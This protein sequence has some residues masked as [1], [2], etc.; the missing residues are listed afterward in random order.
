MYM[1]VCT[2]IIN[3]YYRLDVCPSLP[4]PMTPPRL[5]QN[6]SCTELLFT[7]FGSEEKHKTA[8][9]RS[10]FDVVGIAA[11][12]LNATVIQQIL[13]DIGCNVAPSIPHTTSESAELLE[14]YKQ[15]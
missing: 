1:Y 4:V 2:E 8:T 7:T 11:T 13:L 9:N 12:R 3:F 10:F 14:K 6:I 15:K 5:P